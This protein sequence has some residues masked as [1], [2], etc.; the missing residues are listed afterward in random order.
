[1]RP[2]LW[3]L[4][5]AP[6]FRRT[7][8]RDLGDIYLSAFVACTEPVC[9]LLSPKQV[10]LG[11]NETAKIFF[12][13]GCVRLAWEHFNLKDYL[14]LADGGYNCI[15]WWGITNCYRFVTEDPEKLLSEYHRHLLEALDKDECLAIKSKGPFFYTH[16]CPVVS[17]VRMR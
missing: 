10:Y 17:V 12:D 11:F 1:M 9:P 15:L 14:C 5:A 7:A 4:D 6:A 3:Q 2:L 13:K 16:D 8:P